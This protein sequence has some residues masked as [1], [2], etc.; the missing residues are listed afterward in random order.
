VFRQ[1]ITLPMPGEPYKAF[2]A[3]VPDLSPPIPLE[4]FQ[5]SVNDA[6]FGFFLWLAIRKP[7]R[8]YA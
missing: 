7:D 2:V 3:F 8:Y 1:L 6:H 5:L 4:W